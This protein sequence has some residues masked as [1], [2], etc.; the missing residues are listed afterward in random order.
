M[1]RLAG[2]ADLLPTGEQHP[3][4]VPPTDTG[5]GAVDL[6]DHHV[7]RGAAGAART[8]RHDADTSGCSESTYCW[9]AVRVT[10]L[11][12]SIRIDSSRTDRISSYT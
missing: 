11:H 6:V 4:E 1:S 9:S 5:V 10:R 7:R 3:R 2:P 12:V 8:G